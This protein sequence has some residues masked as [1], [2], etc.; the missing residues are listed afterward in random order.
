VELSKKRL[1]SSFRNRRLATFTHMSGS[2]SLPYRGDTVAEAETEAWAE[3]FKL[4][5]PPTEAVIEPISVSAV[6]GLIV[7]IP[8]L[9][10]S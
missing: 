3:A 6:A 4:F 2:F 9:G 8:A 10:I 1:A 5:I 7:I